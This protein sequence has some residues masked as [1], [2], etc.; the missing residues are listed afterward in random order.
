MMPLGT[1]P[2]KDRIADMLLRPVNI[3][4]YTNIKDIAGNVFLKAKVT[5]G[6]NNDI[7]KILF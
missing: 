5:N 1:T 7:D 6:G 3:E 2:S 4:P